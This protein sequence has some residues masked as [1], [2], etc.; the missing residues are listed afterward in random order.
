MRDNPRITEILR[1][2]TNNLISDYISRNDIEKD[3][4]IVRQ[5]DGFIST[6]RLK[7]IDGS[8]PLDL[9][10]IFEKFISSIDKDKYLALD[11]KRNTVIKGISHK[12]S[13][14]DT[15]YTKILNFNFLNR[16]SIFKGMQEIKDEILNSH[17]IS[18]YCIPISNDYEGVYL[19]EHGLVSIS[20]SAK[21]MLDTDD[22]DKN[23]YFD[24]YIRPFTESLV[25]TFS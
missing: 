25:L 9:R 23:K 18:L 21:N 13:K 15:L 6:K 14:I 10:S 4:I 24:L 17:D 2:T 5:Y 12:N 20:K 8:I 3:Q 22:I 11:E 19:K 7:R 1:E 16:I